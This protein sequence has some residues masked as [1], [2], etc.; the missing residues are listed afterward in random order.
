MEGHR[1]NIEKMAVHILE[2]AERVAQETAAEMEL[3]AKSNFK[4]TPRTHH[5][6][7]CLRGKWSRGQQGGIITHEEISAEIWQDLYGLKGKEYGYWLENAKRFHGKYAIL[8]ETANVHAGMF[9]N[10][11]MDAIKSAMEREGQGD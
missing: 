9:F 11:M 10:G 8:Q 7:E 6:N 5:A 2:A 4:W 1:A 3:Y